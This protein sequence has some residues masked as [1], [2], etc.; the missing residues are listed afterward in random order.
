[1][2]RVHTGIIGRTLPRLSMRGMWTAGGHKFVTQRPDQR[3][4]SLRRSPRG[5]RYWTCGKLPALAAAGAGG[6]RFEAGSPRSVVPVRVLVAGV[7]SD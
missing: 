6:A 5:A 7:C 1:V 4:D 2:R 3:G